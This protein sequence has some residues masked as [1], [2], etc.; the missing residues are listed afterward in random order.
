MTSNNRIADAYSFQALQKAVETGPEAVRK[1]AG[2][3]SIPDAFMKPRRWDDAKVT[4]SGILEALGCFIRYGSN[5][6]AADII[7][8]LEPQAPLVE[9]RTEEDF[10]SVYACIRKMLKKIINASSVPIKIKTDIKVTGRS[11][12]VLNIL[13]SD[14]EKEIL[15]AFAKRLELRKKPQALLSQNVYWMLVHFYLQRQVKHLAAI[16][17]NCEETPLTTE[18]A[19]LL[20]VGIASVRW[21]LDVDLSTNNSWRFK[22]CPLVTDERLFPNQFHEITTSVM[23]S[24]PACMEIAKLIE[25]LRSQ[26]HHRYIRRCRAP[27]C[28]RLFY[29]AR[30]NA[31]V[32]P[33]KRWKKCKGEWDSYASK[34]KKWL[35]NPQE[36]WD[37]DCLKE[38]FK[39]DYKPRKGL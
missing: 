11:D 28:G 26:S 17:A 4:D 12:F 15:K 7:K 2:D 34:L 21:A 23:L 32:C 5:K 38:K 29:T 25:A 35:Y 31:A 1:L 10:S 24:S 36:I 33:G 3:L 18:Q 16:K 37:D 22:L 39:R 30:S 20:T 27:S 9:D 19:N 6:E 13:P 8:E 14:Q